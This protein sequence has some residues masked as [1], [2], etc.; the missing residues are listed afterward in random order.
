M[1]RDQ[2]LTQREI[3]QA[4]ALWG[5]AA[6]YLKEKA[7]KLWRS[8]VDLHALPLE[9][10]IELRLASTHAIRQAAGVVDIAYGVF[11]STAIFE[12]SPIQRKFQ[13]AHAITQQIQ[14]R[15]ENYETAGQFFLGLEPQGRM[16]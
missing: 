2:P 1:L 10:R 3:G 5:G 13:D 11:G 16:F 8:A 7:A 12:S 15:M 14:G 6:A 9:D 4:E